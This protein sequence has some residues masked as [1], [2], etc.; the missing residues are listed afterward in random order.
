MKIPIRPRRVAA[1]AAA[2]AGSAASLPRTAQRGLRAAIGQRFGLTAANVL[3]GNGSDNILDLI[4]RC[5]AAGRCRTH[6]TSYSP[7][8]WWRACPGSHCRR[9]LRSRH[10][11][12]SRRAGGDGG[13]GVFS[14]QPQCADG[15]GLPAGA[16]RGSLAGDG[17]FAG[18]RRLMSI[19][20]VRART[21]L[22]IYAN[23]IVVRTF[24]KPGAGRRVGFALASEAIS[25]R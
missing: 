17:R 11:P 9:A 25:C 19:L 21:P 7:I 6:G 23:L 24:S 4:T 15:C 14:D 20:A 22:K 16:N 12:R 3:I 10:A 5:F 13:A 1:A 18:G 8:R 2:G